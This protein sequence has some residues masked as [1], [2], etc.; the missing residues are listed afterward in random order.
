MRLR[1][2]EVVLKDNVTAGISP[3]CLM[4]LAHALRSTSADVE[5]PVR[6]LPIEGV[7]FFRLMDGRHRFMASVLAGR[8]DV[9]AVL[10][11]PDRVLS[12]EEV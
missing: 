3:W 7:P 4:S 9:L 2:S 1:L 11:E 8:P 10:D 12:M 6:V 5:P